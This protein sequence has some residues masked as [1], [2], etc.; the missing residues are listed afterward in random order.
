MRQYEDV[1]REVLVKRACVELMCDVC[2][3]KAKYPGS[4]KW[5]VNKRWSGYGLLRAVET[6]QDGNE[7]IELDICCDCALWLIQQIRAGVINR[8]TEQE[9][10]SHA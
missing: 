7:I 2:G 6:L 10:S 1:T 3:A 5:E 8:V 4:S 9:N